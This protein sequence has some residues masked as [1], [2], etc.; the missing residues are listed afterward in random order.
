MKTTLIFSSFAFLQVQAIHLMDLAESTR[1]GDNL[2]VQTSQKF[3]E[4]YLDKDDPANEIA[5]AEGAKKKTSTI[6]ASVE[7]ASNKTKQVAKKG[8]LFADSKTTV[9]SGKGGDSITV[10]IDLQNFNNEQY[11][12]NIVL[13]DTKQK[14]PV[15]FDTGSALMYVVTD[16][17]QHDLCPQEVKYQPG[18]SAKYKLAQESDPVAKCYGKGCVSGQLSQ[19]QVCFSADDDKACLSGA[20]FLAVNEATDIEKDKFSGIVGLSPQSDLGNI[21]AFVD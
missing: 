9:S 19:D 7:K 14:V 15:M 16:K 2:L 17:C 13:G 5:A 11:I 10:G 21:P 20:T 6:L 18:S 12:G 3:W 1:I 4:D 8:D